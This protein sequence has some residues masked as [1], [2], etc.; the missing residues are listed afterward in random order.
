[1]LGCNWLLQA[2]VT[3]ND[4]ETEDENDI[5]MIEMWAENHDISNMKWIVDFKDERCRT[6]V[7]ELVKNYQPMIPKR[8]FIQI[9]LELTDKV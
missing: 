8:S 5:I 6:E 9:A 3:T 2:N 4:H 7:L 1:M